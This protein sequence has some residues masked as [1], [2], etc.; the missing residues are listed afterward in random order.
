MVT[1]ATSLSMVRTELFATMADTQQCLEQFLEERDSGVLLQ[2]AVTNL[3][4]IKGILSLIELTGAELLAQEMQ[5]LAMDIPAGADQDRNEQLTAIN[6]ALHVLRR[7]L[8]QLEANWIEMPELML[9]A[10]NKLRCASGQPKLPESFFFSAKLNFQHP[11]PNT[12]D[13]T[14]DWQQLARRLRQM[15]QVGLLSVL[16]EERVTASYG[17]MMRALHRLD[18][19]NKHSEQNNFFWVAAATFESM[20][21][22]KLLLKKSRK[23][24]FSR[25]DREIKL[26]LAN[27]GHTSPRGLLKDL[28]YLIALADSDG[29]LATQVRTAASLPSL[30]FTDHMLADEYQRLSGPG[31]NVLRSLSV[32]IQEELSSV[33]DA[34]DLIER[35]TAS[36]EQFTVLHVTVAKL[37]KILAMV[38]LSTASNALKNHLS[39]VIHWQAAE[40]V[41]FDDLVKLA[42]TVIYVEGLVLGLERGQNVQVTEESEAEVFARHQL[43]EARIVVTEEAKA[44]LSMTKRAITAYFESSGDRAHLDNIP[45]VLTNVRGGLQFIDEERAAHLVNACID[46]IQNHMINAMDMP[47]EQ[48]LESLADALTSLEYYLEGGSLLNRKEDREVLDLAQESIQA[49][50]VQIQQ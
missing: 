7:Y 48:A 42:D 23:Q 34:V 31:T 33:K 27:G 25:I 28:L 24:L 43:M 46:Y 44:G 20:I 17:L 5:A 26:H 2:Q 14:E 3:Q 50:G 4:Q 13:I 32:A 8:E 19:I 37:E 22:G 9:P 45:V 6:N 38:G 10:I 41:Q 15:Y 29:T 49:L 35:G 1:G 47:I 40:D 16:K 21:D 12:Q 18:S 30:P 36:F 11:E 39:K